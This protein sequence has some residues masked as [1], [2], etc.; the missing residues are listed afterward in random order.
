MV[1]RLA[2]RFILIAMRTVD[3]EIAR[4]EKRAGRTEALGA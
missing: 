3:E 1:M 4:R 2:N